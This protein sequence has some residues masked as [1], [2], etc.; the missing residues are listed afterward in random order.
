MQLDAGVCNNPSRAF[1][2][3]IN[4]STSEAVEA[5]GLFPAGVR[6]PADKLMLDLKLHEQTQERLPYSSLADDDEEK[7]LLLDK[8]SDIFDS[9]SC[10]TEVRMDPPVLPP[11]ISCQLLMCCRTDRKPPP[12][13]PF[14]RYCVFDRVSFY[15][16]RKKLNQLILALTL[17]PACGRGSARVSG[18][19]FGCPSP[20]STHLSDGHRAPASG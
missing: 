7:C 18:A 13:L 3:D 6:P 20:G 11:C 4:E 14:L 1:S 2:R 8:R 17:E 15:R 19:V 9:D 5:G 10:Q 16:S 12:C